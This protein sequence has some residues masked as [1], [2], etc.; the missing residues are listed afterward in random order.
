MLSQAS[1]ASSS[2][3]QGCRLHNIG[4]EEALSTLSRGGKSQIDSFGYLRANFDVLPANCC[5][6]MGGG[7]HSSP[8]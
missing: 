3:V 5:L 2:L 1:R 4:M 6:P 7:T 8:L